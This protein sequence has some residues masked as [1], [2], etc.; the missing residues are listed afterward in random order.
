MKHTKCYIKD[1]PRPQFVRKSWKSLNGKWNFYLDYDNKGDELSFKNGFP[2]QT[3]IEVPF[4]YTTEASG[5]NILRRC[6]TLWYSRC[7]EGPRGKKR[8]ILNFEGSDYFT[9]VYINGNFIGQ[10]EGG[11]QRFSLDITDYLNYEENLLVVKVNDSY[12]CHQPRGK[13]K[14]LDECFGCWYVETTGIWKTVWLEYVNPCHLEYMRTAVDV[15]NVRVN[16]EGKISGFKTGD[17]KLR[18]VISFDDTEIINCEYSIK[19][20]IYRQSINF[21]FPDMQFNVRYWSNFCPDLYDIRYQLLENGCIIDEI[22]SYFGVVKYES[23][24]NMIMQNY[25]YFYSKM[26]LDQG[27][28]NQSGLTPVSEDDIVKDI[29]LVKEMGF[30]GIRKHQKIEDDRFY[31]YCDIIGISVWLESPSCYDFSSEMRAKFTNQWIKIVNDHKSFPCIMAYVLF[32][33]SWGVTNI[34]NI[35]EQQLFTESIY[36]LTKSIDVGRFVISN[37]GW[38]HTKSDIIT[39]HNY[40]PYGE[41]LKEVYENMDEYLKGNS[42]NKST[43]RQPFAQGYYYEGQPVIVSEYGGIAFNKD[44][45]NGWGYGAM[46]KDEN[47]FINR[48]NSLTDYIKSN[49]NICG[50]CV[51]QL[52]DVYQEVNGLLTQKR[53]PKIKTEVIRDINNN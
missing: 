12:S 27:Y 2:S 22:G 39:L 15:D 29:K 40:L 50:Y 33:E 49:K 18:T 14:W 6:D 7:I 44:R 51:T 10:N 35:R 47:E 9:C 38:E 16:F 53:I 30:N 4:S 13:Q 52:T 36:Y 42:H 46:V 23:S 32:N 19:E 28:F 1:Y 43:V 3:T 41:D 31:Y 26:V 11:Y 48:Y 24:G 21:A 5:V 34:Y 25:S 20:E 37:D 45:D 17:L 8:T